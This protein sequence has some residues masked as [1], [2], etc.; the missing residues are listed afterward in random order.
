M[1]QMSGL[2][3][4]TG[5]ISA[6]ALQAAID[7]GR[8]GDEGADFIRSAEQIRSLAEVF[9]GQI[10]RTP[11]EQAEYISRR[12]SREMSGQI[13]QFISLLKDNNQCA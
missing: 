10:D 4:F 7:A 3:K 9:G 12:R 2:E 6:L 13:H 1:E 11:L 8:L 5:T